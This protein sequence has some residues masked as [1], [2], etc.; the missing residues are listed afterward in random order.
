MWI[1]ALPWVFAG[2]GVLSLGLGLVYRKLIPTQTAT[3]SGTTPFSERMAALRKQRSRKQRLLDE[4]LRQRALAE[5]EEEEK[6]LE[7]ANQA[8]VAAAG[9]AEVEADAARLE[10]FNLFQSLVEEAK[11]EPKVPVEVEPSELL[12]RVAAGPLS[13][14]MIDLS[15]DAGEDWKE[16]LEELKEV[17]LLTE[18]LCD[19]LETARSEVVWR[20]ELKT[21]W[22][23]R[24]T[25]L[26]RLEKSL[27]TKFQ[28]NEHNN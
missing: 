18:D 20:P 27:L 8:A 17:I 25:V 7:L 3:S 16:A 24:L 26:A 19:L 28:A 15:E 4:E 5:I 23:L 9:A 22:E 12:S 1:E 11:D 14:L 6:Q 10:G 2:I 13:R 21:A